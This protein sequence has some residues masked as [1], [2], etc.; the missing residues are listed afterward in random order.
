MAGREALMGV[1]EIAEVAGVTRAAVT[2][3]RSRHRDFPSPVAEL[4]SGPVFNAAD[5]RRWLQDHEMA[6]VSPSEAAQWVQ[7]YMPLAERILSAYMEN[8][9]WPA[10]D[11]LQRDLDRN[12][13]PLDVYTAY[14]E[15]PRIHG[16]QYA[17]HP[18][19]VSLPLRVLA[20]VPGAGDLIQACMAVVQ[21]AVA[22]YL[23]DVE[24][25]IVT[26]DDEELRNSVRDHALLLKAGPLVSSDY[27]N[28]TAG[29][30][31]GS[32]HWS[33]GIHG[34]M[35]RRF[36]GIDS[37]DLYFA[38][39]EEIIAERRRPV[40]AVKS[41]PLRAFAVMPFGHEWSQG[42]YD[43]VKRTVE[44]IRD[45]FDVVLTRA[46]EISR[47]GKITD[48]IV[49]ELA[50][51]DVIICDITGGNPNVMWELGYAQSLGRPVVILNQ[52]VDSTPF[53]LRDWRQVSYSTTPTAMDERKIV[54]VLRQAFLLATAA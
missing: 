1:T 49:N 29:G 48:Q 54:E 24:P 2:N 7:R 45:E 12:G 31:Y 18:A 9:S 15:I 35:A 50:T 20:H 47:P 16:E 5:V 27:P 17:L 44:T 52:D 8:E 30:S 22:V 3:W 42:I 4:R 32:G 34:P 36:V 51:A 23:S 26:S 39:Q 28:P 13:V 41:R 10:A 21:R 14:M 11:E 37:T 53:D 19:S 6:E 46:D 38:I 33:F 43:M 25:A 40:V